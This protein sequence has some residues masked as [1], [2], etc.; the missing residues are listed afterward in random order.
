MLQLDLTPKEASILAE[1]LEAALTELRSEIG[2]TDS[3]EFK[4]QLKE[5]QQI[6]ERTHAELIQLAKG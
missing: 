3:H 5:R 4:E 1:T 2:H 6:L